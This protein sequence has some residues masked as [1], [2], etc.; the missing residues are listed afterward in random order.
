M[1]ASERRLQGV[2]SLT[3]LSGLLPLSCTVVI[4]LSIAGVFAGMG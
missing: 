2:V 4:A 3:V 1:T